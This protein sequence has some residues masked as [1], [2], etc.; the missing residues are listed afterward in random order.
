MKNKKWIVIICV[1]I[2]LIASFIPVQST[3]I[4]T[5]GILN[6]RYNENLEPHNPPLPG[7]IIGDEPV[8]KVDIKKQILKQNHQ[9]SHSSMNVD[10]IDLINQ[11]NES[12]IL[13]YLQS[14]T[15]FGPRVTGETGCEQAAEYIY[16]E[17]SSMGLQVRYDNWIYG[18]YDS[19]NVEATLPGIDP[20][21]DDIYI[22]CGHYDTVPGAP[23]ADDDGSGVAAVLAA[24]QVMSQYEFNNTIRFVT[25]SGEE[26]G[27][28]GSYMYVQEAY[29]NG[30]DIKGVLNADM[31][32]FALDDYQASYLNIF[33]D[34]A[35]EWLYDFT[36]NINQ[37]Y[38]EYIDLQL[39]HGGWTWGSDHYY[40]W[41]VG[42]NAL[43][44]HEYEFN[45]YYH[46]PDDTIE[47]MNLTYDKKGTRLL[48]ATLA[49]LAQA[50][51]INSPPDK[52]NITGLISGKPKKE[53][54]YK[55]S[56]TD[57]ENDRIYYYI[58]W[59]DTTNTGWIGPYNSSEEISLSH[60]WINSGT[61]IIKAKAKDIFGAEGNWGTLQVT[62]PRLKNIKGNL[63]LKFLERFSNVFPILKYLLKN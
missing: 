24:A 25:F 20:S 38:D 21:S 54:E 46:S 2:F 43:F 50:S 37:L 30:D 13:D 23:G 48:I 22:I 45:H 6:Y 60:S 36:F 9:I 63:I 3:E 42:Y 15:N 55:F 29:N 57:P 18:G 61:Y 47:H 39:I 40:F 19:N 4:S 17:F 56:S 44:Y 35:S 12:M 8:I 51:S 59:G 10:I 52:P 58:D 1:S 34:D 16:N 11:I 26:E 7:L 5:K 53:Y 41:E 32:G 14:L 62:I 49:E 28:F 31:I 27:L 33:E